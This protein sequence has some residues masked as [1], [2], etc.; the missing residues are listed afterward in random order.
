MKR[1][2]LLDV[3]VRKGTTVFELLP[4]KDQAL[5]IWRNALFVLNLALHCVDGIRRLHLE[6]DGLS[7]QG[8]NEDLHTATKTQK[9][10]IR[11]F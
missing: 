6:S 10:L 1:A 3:V 9:T 4:G 11:F 5:L 7:G 8:L 2:L